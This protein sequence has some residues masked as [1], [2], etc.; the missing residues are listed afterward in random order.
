MRGLRDEYN[1][2]WI[3]WLHLL[4]L[5]L[6]L[7]SMRTA[8]NQWLLK[9][10]SIP[11]WTTS[12]FSSTDWLGSDLRIGHSFSFRRPLV[13][14]PQLNTQLSLEWTELFYNFGTECH[15][16]LKFPCYSLL[17]CVFVATG[18]CLSNRCRAMD[19]SAYIHCSGNKPLASSGLPL[20]L[21]Y[22]VFQASCQNMLTDLPLWM[23]KDATRYRFPLTRRAVERPRV[24]V[25]VYV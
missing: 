11:Y 10:R 3:G 9:T 20:W 5:L 22:S 17:L 16:V 4:E 21:H 6:Q 8:L 25:V 15:H 14:T 12:V 18:T 23:M 7:Q 19:Y 13:N 24:P 2:F 1:G